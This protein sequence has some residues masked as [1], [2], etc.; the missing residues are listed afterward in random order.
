VTTSDISHLGAGFELL[1]CALKLRNPV[2]N[3]ISV[4]ARPEEALRAREQALRVLVPANAFPRTKRFGDLGFVEVGGLHDVKCTCEKR[5]RPF[6]SER[7]GLLGR[8]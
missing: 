3:E 4:I 7:H 6:F 5:W 8:Q 1:F 2:R